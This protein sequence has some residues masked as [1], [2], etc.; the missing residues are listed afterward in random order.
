MDV[1]GG[2]GSITCE[3]SRQLD[4]EQ[5][6]RLPE[7]IEERGKALERLRDMMLREGNWKKCGSMM[8]RSVR[9]SIATMQEAGDSVCELARE[10]KS[11]VLH[12][13][14]TLQ[15]RATGQLYKPRG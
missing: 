7:L 9:A 3:L 1:V 14:E 10:K 2:I 4:Q 8:E 13:L 5:Y 6:N 15:K 12:Q 11:A